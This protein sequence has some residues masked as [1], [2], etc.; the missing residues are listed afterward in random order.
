MPPELLDHIFNFLAL[1]ALPSL[2]L[3]S[4]LFHSLSTRIFYRH[5]P[6]LPLAATVRCLTTLASPSSSALALAEYVRTFEIG[7]IDVHSRMRKLLRSFYSL[8]QRAL[9]R[10]PALTSLS[11]LLPGPTAFYLPKSPSFQLTKLTVSCDFDKML[12]QFLLTQPSLKTAL[13]CGPDRPHTTIHID[14]LPAL[15]RISASPLILAML[16]PGR[17]V[18]EVELC[19][20]HPWLLNAAVLETTMQIVGFSRGPVRSLQIIS[21]LTEGAA[22]VLE[23]LECIPRSLGGLSNLALHAVSGSVTK[24]LLDGL[25]PILAQFKSL[26]SLMLL[27]KNKSDALHDA[28]LTPGLPAL[29][30]SA[31]TTLECVALPQATFVRNA[32]YGWVTLQD[33][34]RLLADREQMLVHREREVR[35]REEELQEEQR[36]LEERERRLE[37]RVRVLRAEA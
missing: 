32:R 8:L 16:V 35:E 6:P 23:A 26:R 27:S 14:A 10:M 19:L 25:P 3:T 18:K 11:F 17:P 9:S 33:L 21:H 28:A 37:E 5:I 1:D 22:T 34:E 30:A 36:V 7:D 24:E 20:V 4:R 2:A 15:H 29:W 13:F 31:C 12:A